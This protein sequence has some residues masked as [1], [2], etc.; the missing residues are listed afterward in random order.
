MKHSDRQELN[1]GVLVTGNIDGKFESGY[2]V[3]VK[4]G[5]EELKGVLYHIPQAPPETQRRKNKKAKSSQGDSQRPKCP[6]TGYN[7]FFSE[8]HASLKAENGG[9]KGSFTKDIVNMWSNLSE[10]DRKVTQPLFLS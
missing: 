2:L 8:Q 7:F 4:M 3:T 5:S 6:R 10:S 9:Q 1:P